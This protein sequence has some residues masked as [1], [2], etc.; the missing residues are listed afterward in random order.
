LNGPARD[1]SDK[2]MQGL[3]LDEWRGKETNGLSPAA[4]TALS[5]GFADYSNLRHRP[6]DRHSSVQG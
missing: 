5:D 3:V 1:L 4:F 6:S 2:D